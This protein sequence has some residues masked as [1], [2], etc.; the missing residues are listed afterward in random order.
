MDIVVDFIYPPIPDR[1]QDY[2]AYDADQA[3]AEF[4]DGSWHDL[5]PFKGWGPTREAAL[6]DLRAAYDDDEALTPDVIA[7]IDKAL[8]EARPR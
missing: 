1:S 7:A 4:E 6:A 2:C 3:D 8:L 5:T